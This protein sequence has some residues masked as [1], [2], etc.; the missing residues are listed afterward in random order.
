VILR[1]PRDPQEKANVTFIETIE[2]LGGHDVEWGITNRKR[3]EEVEAE[4]KRAELAA[5][6]SSLAEKELA[7]VTLQ[8]Q[9]HKFGQIYTQ[10]VGRLFADLDALEAQIVRL[11]EKASPKDES[12]RARAN[13][14]QARAD[15]S[16][17][18]VQQA[19]PPDSVQFNPSSE[20]K[21]L[22]REAALKIHP[23]LAT[24]AATRPMRERV[25]AKVNAA[26]ESGDEE[27]LREILQNWEHD[28]E[29]VQGKDAASI[30]VRLIRRIAQVNAARATVERKLHELEKSE[31]NQLR[32]K[33]TSEAEC[34]RDLLTEMSQDLKSQIET[35]RVRLDVLTRQSKGP[36]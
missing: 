11:L 24:D 5:I 6:E 33:V 7:L 15:R 13:D 36:K 23:D 27:T 18:A 17:K 16:A 20:L 3:P 19:S 29:S 14:A 32:Q 28:P 4:A 26:Y 34:G 31:L 9:L 22:Y 1:R 2:T 21:R 12:L 30:L 10:K 8:T 25:M 35:A